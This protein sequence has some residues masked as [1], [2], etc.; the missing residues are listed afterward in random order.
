MDLLKAQFNRIQ[1]QLAAL[2]LSQKMLTGTLVAIMVITLAWWAHYAGTPEMEAL[3]NRAMAGDELVRA[4]QALNAYRIDNKVSPDGKLMVPADDHVHALSV[5]AYE[6][7]LPSDSSD[8]MSGMLANLNPFDSQATAQ[9]KWSAAGVQLL[10]QVICNLPSVAAAKVTMDTTTEA[11]IGA[12]SIEPVAS[13][14][15]TMKKGRQPDRKLVDAIADVVCSFNAGLKR[16]RVSVIIDGLP[17]RVSDRGPNGGIASAAELDEQLAAYERRQESKIQEIL[18]YFGT[19]VTAQVTAKI[20]TVSSRTESVTHPK[21]QVKEQKTET[22]TSESHSAAP[23]GAEPGAVPNTG[24]ANSPLSV[25]TAPAPSAAPAVGT[26]TTTERNRTD[27]QVIADQVK[28]TQDKP[29]GTPTTVSA[30]VTVPRSYFTNLLKNTQPEL[31]DKELEK[32]VDALVA[33]RLPDIKNSIANSIGLADKNQIFVDAVYEPPPMMAA[34]GDGSELASASS[35]GG[36]SSVTQS[37]GG[38]AKEIAVGVLALVSLFMVS[39][40]VKKSAPAVQLATGGAGGA[41]EPPDPVHLSGTEPIAGQVAEGGNLLDGMELDEDA[42]R[43]QQM[44][45]QVT[46]MVQENPDAA[47]NLVKRWLNRS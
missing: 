37:I 46:T 21:V 12:P 4:Q 9:R 31:K 36:L 27:N 39:S 1:Q 44:V 28:E 5:L 20:D 43:A 10:Q 3:S 33:A 26:S 17:Y 29:A 32:A 38:H 42:I 19:G 13:A 34:V 47:A 23:A 6:S 14:V 15:I 22:E 24:G 35:G 16:S 7:A 40:M 8:V 2:T 30:S 41:I 18:R 45:D 25:G 11:K